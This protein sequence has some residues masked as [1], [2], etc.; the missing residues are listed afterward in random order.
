VS[1]A[2]VFGRGAAYYSTHPTV[3]CADCGCPADADFRDHG[4][5]CLTER[6]AATPNNAIGIILKRAREHPRLCADDVHAAMDQAGVSG[7]A[8]G[9][10]WQYAIRK[11]WI[12]EDGVV[13]SLA[14]KTKGHRI[15]VYRSLLYVAERVA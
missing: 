6:S 15:S 3:P 8:R 10:A 9:S 7:P 2:T 14:P 4:G 11:E 1:I 12:E 5:Q 13:R